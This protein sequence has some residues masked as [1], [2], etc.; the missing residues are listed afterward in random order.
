MR[1]HRQSPAGLPRGLAVL[2][3]VAATVVVVAGIRLV[4]WLIAPTLLALVI[5]IAVSPVQNWL[6]RKGWP[7]WLTTVVL[8][9]LVYGVLLVLSFGIFLS[10]A[11]LAELLPQYAA[12]ANETAGSM[13]SALGRL[14]VGHD[15][16]QAVAGSLDYG[17]LTTA[18]T[19]LL[20]AVASAVSSVV[21]LLALLLF[22]SADYGRVAQR[23]ADVAAE[24]PAIGAALRTFVRGTRRYLVVTTVFGLIVAVLD[25]VALAIIGIPLAVTWGLLSF[26]TNYIPNIGFI[27]GVAPPALLALLIGGPKELLLVIAVYGVLNFV[28]QS[29]IQPRFVGDA[30]GLSA[31]ATFVALVFWAWLLG[32]LG[33]ILAIPATLL[34]KALLVDVD[35]RARWANAF[36]GAP[37]RRP[38]RTG[39]P[40]ARRG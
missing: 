30:V 17:K 31:L 5:V 36:I 24:R 18:L 40:F 12:K 4:A 7:G 23:I 38:R 22:L 27:I 11:R 37:D 33:A 19:Q 6:R 13:T 1:T 3:G 15:Q 35:P 25:A 8:V 28:L 39:A 9:V 34:V 10:V 16:I 2:L 20:G 29:L 21:F 32:P 26:V 14:G